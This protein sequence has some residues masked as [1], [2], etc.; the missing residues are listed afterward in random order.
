[1]HAGTHRFGRGQRIAAGRELHTDAGGGFAVESRRCGI[2]LGTELNARYVFEPHA[3]SV[4]V[5]A[6][7]HIAKLCH[8][9]ELAAHHHGGGNALARHIGQAANFTG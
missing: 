6:Q 3:G 9:A 1:M 4:S 7:H 5:G 8:A 2:S